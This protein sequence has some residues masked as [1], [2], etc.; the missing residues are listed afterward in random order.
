[1]RVYTFVGSNPFGGIMYVPLGDF[2]C[3]KL[4]VHCSTKCD[5]TFYNKVKSRFINKKGKT[6]IALLLNYYA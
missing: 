5:E 6:F 2:R 3:E 4:N 1:M